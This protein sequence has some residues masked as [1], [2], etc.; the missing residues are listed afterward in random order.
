M[1]ATILFRI[2]SQAVSS[3]CLSLVLYGFETWSLILKKED[4][5]RVF[6]IIWT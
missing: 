4:R 6:E 5:L 1:L 2:F 3:I